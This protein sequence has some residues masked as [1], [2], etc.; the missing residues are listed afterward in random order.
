MFLSQQ[1]FIELQKIPYVDTAYSKSSAIASFT[2]TTE[3]IH[4]ETALCFTAFVCQR[5]NSDPTKRG[6][7]LHKVSQSFYS[8]GFLLQCF[9]F[10]QLELS[11][12]IIHKSIL[13]PERRN[14]LHSLVR[15][16]TRV[17]TN[18]V[19]YWL[20]VTGTFS[21]SSE[22]YVYSLKNIQKTS[23]DSSA[24]CIVLYQWKQKEFAK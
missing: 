22:I 6:I 21:T 15:A 10:L 17:R 11:Q 16:Q 24:L 18:I 5:L 12:Q 9:F 20:P 14:N 19:L 7:S 8:I 13:R 4:V 3:D 1:I 23:I 2:L